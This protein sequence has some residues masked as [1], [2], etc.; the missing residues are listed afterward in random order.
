MLQG[1]GGLCL[2]L[3]NDDFVVHVASF[4]G[5]AIGTISKVDCMSCPAA[6]I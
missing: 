3:M 2:S 1:S 5:N 6:G 4:R